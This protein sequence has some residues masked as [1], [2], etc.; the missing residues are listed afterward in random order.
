MSIDAAKT[1]SLLQ[2]MLRTQPRP[3]TEQAMPATAVKFSD[4]LDAALERG[5]IPSDVKP[6]V[7][8]QAAELLQLSTLRSSIELLSD[9]S[10]GDGGM[11]Q[12]LATFSASVMPQPSAQ[13]QAYLASMANGG[14]DPHTNRTSGQPLPELA[15]EPGPKAPE[16]VERRREQL[17]DSP[18]SANLEQTIEKASQRYGV[19]AGLIKAVIKAES[20]FNPRAVSHAGAQGL[21]QL[22]P[23]TARGL[24]VSDPFDPDQ[25]VLAG[26]RFLK[27][28][29]ERYN[30]NLDSALAAYNWGPGNVD[31]RP[32]RLPRETRDY[33]VKVKQYYAGYT[34]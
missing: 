10:S 29:L 2:S 13:L 8:Q 25:N 23:A 19:E 6:E 33:L 26:T 7:V 16:Q 5:I 1:L 22:M 3:A 32:D 31:R 21:M 11:S 12:P 24:G 14:T 15:Q 34:G 9:H 30:G 20:N 27:G 17:P 18:R 28:L 4:R